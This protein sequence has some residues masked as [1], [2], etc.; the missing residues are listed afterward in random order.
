VLA[1][2]TIIV[3]LN[4]DGTS[5][6]DWGAEGDSCTNHNINFQMFTT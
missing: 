3:Q 2:Q 1:S 4:Q 5:R 6:R